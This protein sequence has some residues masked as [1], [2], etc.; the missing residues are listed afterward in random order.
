M[1]NI[2]IP[3]Y[4]E[5]AL[6]I[7][8]KNGYE[9]YP[10]GGCVR[11]SIMGKTPYDWDITT[12]ALPDEMKTVFC[13]CRVIETGIQHGT[14]TVFPQEGSPSLEITTFRTDGDYEDHRHP[15]HVLFTN[16]LHEDLSRRDFTI[17]AMALGKDIVDPFGGFKDLAEKVIRCVGEPEQRFEEDALRILRALRFASVLGFSIEAET[18]KAME[19][20]KQLLLHIAPERIYSEWKKMLCG[21]AAVQVLRRYISVIG[22]FLPELLPMCGFLQYNPHHCYDVWEH[23]LHAVE[24]TPPC[25]TFR[26]AALFH[27]VGKPDTF[28]RDADG[29]GHF[30]GHAR[31]SAEKVTHILDRLRADNAAKE[32]I[33]FL[34]ANH[35]LS[36]PPEEILLKKR[37]R[38]F[39]EEAVHDLFIIQRADASA[40]ANPEEKY[41]ELDCAEQIF[42]KILQ[43]KQCFSLKDLMVTGEDLKA[44]MSPGPEMGKLLSFLLE[45]V[46]EG[47]CANEKSSLLS[48]AQK[49]L[50]ERGRKID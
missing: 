30:Y 23:S 43:E 19:K 27:D 35:G 21:Q 45:K 41:R 34:V 3:E 36:L 16:S 6:L 8:Q 48:A 20:K 37:L 18:A 39:G 47:T 12:S 29:I 46:M 22:Q 2:A 31:K 10:V 44:Y 15:Q 5:K 32:K 4:V 26:M 7:L 49:W 28:F 50:Q 13:D 42:N 33:E 14:L 9:A 11:D 1:I 25:F 24:N 38:K 17:N 40:L